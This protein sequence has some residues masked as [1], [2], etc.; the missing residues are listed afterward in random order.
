LAAR[1]R[2]WRILRG[3]TRD[4]LGERLNTDGKN[5]YRLEGGTENV[6][7]LRASRIAEV[8]QVP[9]G[10]LID[11]VLPSNSWTHE[12]EAL[13]W[14]PQPRGR[15]RSGLRASA[16]GHGR[17]P[18]SVPVLDVQPVGGAAGARD[19]PSVIG[20]VMPPEGR[21]PTEEGLFL[22]KVVGDSMAPRI[23]PGTWCLFGRSFTATD[24]LGAD[25]LVAEREPGGLTAWIVKRIA[26]VS[27]GDDDRRMVQLQSANRAY[28]LRLRSTRGSRRFRA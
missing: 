5:I 22:A 8:L 21:H 20:H 4:E 16:Q 23:P 14:R 13:G 27:I 12:L 25:V 3:L 1:L 24:L 28:P 2:H 15:R 6:A 7:L 17:R 11:G 18:R 26:Q 9:L 10:E 19:E